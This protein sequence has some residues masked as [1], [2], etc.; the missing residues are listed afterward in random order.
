M[1]SPPPK[2]PSKPSSK[3]PKTFLGSI[4]QAF[5]SVQANVDFSKIPLKP[6]ARV[7]KLVVEA[8]A[9]GK[10]QEYPLVGEHYLLGR[11][12]K[13]DIVVRSPIVSQTH[14]ALTRDRGLP[15]QP[16]VLKDKGST[17]GIYRHKKRLSKRPLRHGD[18]LTLGPE[19]LADAVTVRYIDPPPWYITTL[20]YGVY[21][22]TGFTSLLALW[23]VGIEWQKFSIH[24]LP[25]SV[26]GPVLVT[27]E[28]GTERVPLNELPN[29]NHRENSRLQDYS[30][31]LPKA[32]VASEDSRFYWH[33]GVDPWGIAR[34]LKTNV[35]E[36]GIKEGASTIT[37]QLARN[38]YRDYVGIEDS[39]ARK[40]REAIVALKLETFYSKDSLMLLYLNRVYLGNNLYGFEDA[41]Q[42]YFDKDA[43]D[44]S[45][46]EAATLVGILPAPNAFNPVQDYQA[47]VDYRDRVLERMVGQG[48]ISAEEGRRA[49]RSRI[50]ISPKARE[51]LRSTTAPYFYSYI[52]EELNQVLGQDLVRE[53]NFIVETSIDLEAQA[54]AESALRDTIANQG[55]SDGFSQGAVVTLNTRNGEIEALVGGTDYAESQFN[56][57]SQAL[58]QPGSTFKVFA[59]AAALTQGIPAGES[60]SCSDL[61]WGGQFYA[62]CRSGGGALDMYAGMARSENVVAIRIAQEVGLGAVVDLAKDMGITSELRAEP[63]LI[64]GQSEVT[65]LEI[66][67]AFAAFANGGIWNRPHGIQRV[68]DSGECG[69]VEDPSTCRVIYDFSQSADAGVQVLDPAVADTMVSM[70]RGV[71]QGGTGRNAYIG[72]GEAGKTGTTNDNVDMWF[73]GYVPGDQVATGIWLGNDENEPTYG[74]SARAAALWG[75]YMGKVLR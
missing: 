65:P 28:D 70:M 48:M 35:E 32:V 41:S 62:G 44:L 30:P 55:A 37:Q 45:V 1:T 2:P 15:G 39:A 14:L 7:P 51:Q 68:L 16:F 74:S 17:N 69:D 52:F 67:G 54:A 43:K 72:R 71:I 8:D 29:I 38:T 31:F 49:R 58:R 3:P 9:S 75:D 27:A 5:H 73:I 12:S 25:E 42:F 66:T 6:D 21:G 53:G 64:L 61:N 33:P 34:A 24:P 57:A 60:F 59:Y 47:A 46:G 4:T 26:Q 11:S 20:R 10:T 36:G 18:I 56:R 50:E 23:I 63:G 22:A 40:V 19:E 13:N